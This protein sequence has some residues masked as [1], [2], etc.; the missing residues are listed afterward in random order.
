[1]TNR[2]ILLPL[3]VSSGNEGVWVLPYVEL[4]ETSLEL[5]T[6]GKLYFP[7]KLVTHYCRKCKKRF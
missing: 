5:T 4:V 7:S 1:M 3:Q 6:I 2:L